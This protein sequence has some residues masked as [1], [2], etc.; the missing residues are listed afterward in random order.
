MENM[1]Y[2][3]KALVNYPEAND[4]ETPDFDNQLKSGVQ[5]F[6]RRLLDENRDATSFVI[7][8]V[9]NS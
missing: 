2:N 1:K 4:I 3:I 6:V 5:E 7:T 9:A 8:I